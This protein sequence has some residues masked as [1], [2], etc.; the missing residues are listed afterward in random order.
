MAITISYALHYE[1]SLDTGGLTSAIDA[2][3]LEGG[4]L[5]MIGN[6]GAASRS[7]FLDSDGF[8][9]SGGPYSG[10]G[11]A[12]AQLA[13]GDV[14]LVRDSGNEFVYS[15][16][17]AD[18]RVVRGTYPLGGTS[19]VSHVDVAALDGGGF[20]IAYEQKVG[21]GD[22]D[23]RLRILDPNGSGAAPIITVAGTSDLEQGVSVAG[24]VGGGIAVAWHR[25]VGAETEMWLAVYE[26][27]GDVRFAPRLQ[28]F[29]GTINRNASL[30]ALP[31]GGFALAYEGSGVNG[32]PHT[33][34]FVALFDPHSAYAGRKH[35]LSHE[36]DAE[37]VDDGAPSATLL[38]NGMIAVGWLRT[39]PDGAT[40]PHF[41]L[42]DPHSALELAALDL[43]GDGMSSELAVAGMSLGRLA[44]FHTNAATGDTTGGLLE[45]VRTTRGDEA[46]NVLSGDSLRDIIFGGGADT[47]SGGGN[48]DALD[49]GEG[50]D[51]FRFQAAGAAAGATVD[52]GSGSDLL[53]IVDGA[54]LTAVGLVSIERML[55][56]GDSGGSPVAK[57]VIGAAQ[58]GAGLA[59]NLE[60]SG[61][62][63]AD[64]F[65]VVLGGAASVDLSQMTFTNF[66]PGADRV[67]ILG[68]GDAETIMGSALGDDI[69]GGGGN[70]RL[71]G[72]G[73]VD[74]LRGGLGNDLYTVDCAGEA[75]ETSGQG[76]DI[77]RS[78]IGYTLGD[79]IERLELIGAGHINGRGNALGNGING[80]AGDN[81]LNGLAGRD[82]LTGGAGA[83][84]FA[85]TTALD[86]PG[87]VDLVADFEVG[88]DRIRLDDAIFG[89][90]TDAALATAFHVG[91]AAADA[92]HR[93]IYNAETGA[94]YFDPDGAGGARQIRFAT[95]DAGLALS[96][97]D[98]IIV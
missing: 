44:A 4:G 9:S 2:V 69:R 19:H 68:D 67:T 62:D 61:G 73:G 79:H 3:G 35:V 16:R 53:H 83:D 11:G 5:A 57:V 23:I 89:G 15:V 30:V 58:I 18:D 86:A 6:E 95:L 80:N 94:L 17:T 97:A 47:I 77:V 28:G 55:L 26:S 93:I 36:H 39:S 98:F 82:M 71:S 12:V 50:D 74:R 45:A 48:A 13:N 40:D 59:S 60:V 1:T 63:S 96:A 41:E 37:E 88:I 66:D 42:V 20:V 24:L 38:S 22:S 49:G 29:H 21:E 92:S 34:I 54:D 72:G 85:F 46:D 27:N 81:I 84:D 25:T 8:Q 14:V 31:D 10:S 91:N 65:Q 7:L 52:G 32:N 51:T 90:L 75:I 76:T 33:D 78:A 43:P 70:D 87:N 56:G 64:W